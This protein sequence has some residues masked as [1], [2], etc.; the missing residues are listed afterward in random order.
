MTDFLNDETKSSNQGSM[1]V[2]RDYGIVYWRET[3]RNTGFEVV[4][5]PRQ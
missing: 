5:K 4:Q 1:V 3:R 2:M